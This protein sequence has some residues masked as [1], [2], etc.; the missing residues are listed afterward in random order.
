MNKNFLFLLTVYVSNEFLIGF[1]EMK[2]STNIIN[3]IFIFILIIFVR[4]KNW[5]IGMFQSFF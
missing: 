3:Y 1:P 2:N 5:F 4:N